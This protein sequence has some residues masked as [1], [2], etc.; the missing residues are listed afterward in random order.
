MQ[1]FVLKTFPFAADGIKAVSVSAGTVA[2]IHDELV[3]GL[4]AA[5]NVTTDE[6]KA[7]EYLRAQERKL[8]NTALT[9][10]PETQTSTGE[11]V[12]IPEGWADLSA[13]ELRELADNFAETPTA[14][15]DEA[16]AAIEAEI[17]KREQA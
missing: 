5:G 11:P 13:K 10:A 6:E 8:E 16:V 2:E 9:G 1:V 12:E 4:E 3:P 17:T 14:N 7:E 15:K